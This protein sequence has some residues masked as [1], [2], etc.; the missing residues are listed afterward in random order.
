M[1]LAIE[2]SNLTYRAGR[3]GKAFEVSNLAMRVP[4]GSV[5][6]FL[7]PNGSGK[8]T[9]IRL[10]LG[11]LRPAAGQITV[12]GEAMPVEYA[13]VLARVGYVPERPHLYPSLTI[14]EAMDLHRSFYPGWDPQWADDLLRSFY[15]DAARPLSVLSKGEMGKVMMLL[16]LAQ[17]P[18]LLVLDEPTDG[19]DPV[20]RR[21]ILGAV[22]DYVT[23]ARATVL[24]SSHLVH[25]LER[26]CDWVGLMDHGR[27]IAELQMQE[28]KS[29]MKRIRLSTA[30]AEFVDAPFTVLAR[31]RTNVVV[32]EMLVRGWTPGMQDYLGTTG[33]VVREV[34]DLDLEEGFVEM[35]RA[36]RAAVTGGR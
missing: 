35:L 27:L 24:I 16:A 25:E 4:T 30:P 11:L 31:D 21:D 3:G 26:I 2:T 12:L 28:F 7:G 32:E 23:D 13:S 8:T 10:L 20:A 33:A 22:L 36:A 15:L 17:R 18:A 5:Y 1:T 29:G 9:T 14:R 6:G 34:I 19:L